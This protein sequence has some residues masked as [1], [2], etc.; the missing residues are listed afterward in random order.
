MERIEACE[1]WFLRR[2]GKISYKDRITN[3][4]VLKRLNTKRTLLDTIKSRKMK[5]FGHTKR[6][7]SIMKNIVEGKLEGTRPRG[8]P[9][10]QWSDNIKQWSGLSLTTCTRLAEDRE[11]WRQISSLPQSGTTR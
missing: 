11:Q 5:F 8:R 7:E 4:E 2:M 3:D 1:M 9:R 10:A 6:H